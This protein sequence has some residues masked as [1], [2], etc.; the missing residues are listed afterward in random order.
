MNGALRRWPV[1]GLGEVKQPGTL[2][3]MRFGAAYILADLRHRDFLKQAARDPK[4]REV[5][6][7]EFAVIFEVLK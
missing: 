2:V 7:D 6:H 3:R 5:Y 1:R 4:L